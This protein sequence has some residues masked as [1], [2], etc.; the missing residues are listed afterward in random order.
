M[1]LSLCQNFIGLLI[2]FRGPQLNGFSSSKKWTAFKFCCKISEFSGNV[3]SRL[4]VFF[5]TFGREFI[6]SVG[7]FILLN[8]FAALLFQKRKTVEKFDST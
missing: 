1:F 2:P 4:G 6:S 5:T 3:L 7:I 8:K